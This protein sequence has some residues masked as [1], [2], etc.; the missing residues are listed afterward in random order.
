M[1]F[2]IV[3]IHKETDN[4]GHMHRITIIKIMFA[5][6]IVSTHL[7]SYLFASGAS[8]ETNKAKEITRLK[9]VIVSLNNC[10][11]LSSA[12][13]AARDIRK[14]VTDGITT[15]DELGIMDDALT[16]LERKNLVCE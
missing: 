6:C 4:E 9:S 2:A 15:W 10:G 3:S 16:E 14:A 12:P 5:I 13:F 7:S 8:G 11:Y 1:L